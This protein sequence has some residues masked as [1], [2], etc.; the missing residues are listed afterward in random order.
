MHLKQLILVKVTFL[1]DQK[2]ENQVVLR[3]FR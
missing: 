3:S 2:G 1:Y